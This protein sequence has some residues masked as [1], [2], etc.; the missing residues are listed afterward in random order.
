MSLFN[1]KMYVKAVIPKGS[2]YYI[3]HH[4]YTYASSKLVLKPSK[5]QLKYFKNK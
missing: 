5:E 4:G 2:L 1:V 3:D